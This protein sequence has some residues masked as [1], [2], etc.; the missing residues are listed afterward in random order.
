MLLPLIFC[1]TIRVGSLWVPKNQWKK[2]LRPLLI[3]SKYS[4]DASYLPIELWASNEE[5]QT[6]R[7]KSHEEFMQLLRSMF[8]ALLNCIEG[9]QRQNALFM[10][11]LEAV[12]SVR[13]V[14]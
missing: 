7:S 9:S 8:A 1:V 6:I 13:M 11:V 12:Q 5:L 3:P 2:P 14:S 10:E 4:F